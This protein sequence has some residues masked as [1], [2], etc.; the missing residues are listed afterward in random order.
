MENN[1]MVE[2]I[3]NTKALCE[4]KLSYFVRDGEI[5]IY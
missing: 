3:Q 1:E 4:A 2:A 5:H